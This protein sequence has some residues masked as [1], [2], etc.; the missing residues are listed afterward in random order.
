MTTHCCLSLIIALVAQDPKADQIKQDLKKL[1]G[2]WV[3]VS[4][5]IEGKKQSALNDK[6]Y[7]IFDGD[8]LTSRIKDKPGSGGI[9]RLDPTKDPRAIDIDFKTPE[10]TTGAL[11]G[12]YQFSDDGT[13][14]LAFAASQHRPVDFP[15]KPGSENRLIEFKKV[16]R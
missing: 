4:T 6:S 7:W 5:E 9:V 15:T 1:N 11:V 14:W 10:G 16:K 13:L 3:A 2:T 12:I 8:K